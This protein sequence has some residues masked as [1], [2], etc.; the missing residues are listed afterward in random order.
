MAFSYGAAAVDK[1]QHYPEYDANGNVI[2]SDI[3]TLEPVTF[4]WV[5]NEL[6]PALVLLGLAVVGIYWTIVARNT[7]AKSGSS[8]GG[9]EASNV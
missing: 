1:L 9:S 6:L 5:I 7:A 2:G 3:V 8:S 4:T